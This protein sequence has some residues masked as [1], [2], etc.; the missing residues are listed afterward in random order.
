MLHRVHKDV[1]HDC[2]AFGLVEIYGCKGRV[3]LSVDGYPF[4]LS[5]CDHVLGHA[6]Q[7]FVEVAVFHLHGTL[8]DL[9]L[10][11]VEGHIQQILHPS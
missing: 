9:H 4:C 1:Y 11:Q 6:G 10:S 5:L 2:L 3:E 7:P 8:S